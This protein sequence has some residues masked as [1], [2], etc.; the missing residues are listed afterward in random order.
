MKLQAKA[1]KTLEIQKQTLS[2][3]LKRVANR[4]GAKTSYKH[5]NTDCTL[6]D[7]LNSHRMNVY[8]QV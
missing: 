7:K 4:S 6:E 3:A 1:E 2:R 8:L 5:R